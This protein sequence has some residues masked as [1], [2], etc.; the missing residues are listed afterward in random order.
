MVLCASAAISKAI[1]SNS[2][3]PCL[4]FGL[5][6]RNR[7]RYSLRINFFSWSSVRLYFGIAATVSISIPYEFTKK[8]PSFAHFAESGGLWPGDARA[9]DKLP[10]PRAAGVAKLADAL[11]LGSNGAIHAGSTPVTRTKVPPEFRRVFLFYRLFVE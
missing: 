7:A 8:S 9:A 10:V 11:D 5:S 4:S 2:L 1:R 3:S 6:E